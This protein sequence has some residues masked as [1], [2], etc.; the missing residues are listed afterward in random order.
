MSA[1]ASVKPRNKADPYPGLASDTTRAPLLRAISA[2]RSEDPLSTTI[3][4]PMRPLFFMPSWARRMVAATVASS[5]RHGSMT[6]IWGNSVSVMSPR[7]DVDL[8]QY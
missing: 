8:A 4:S 3:I 1:L 6:D 5:F 2:D 7:I